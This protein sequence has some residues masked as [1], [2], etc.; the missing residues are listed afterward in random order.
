VTGAGEKLGAL[1][2]IFATGSN[3]VY[4]VRGERG[5]LL[6]PATDDVITSID[7]TSR[8]IT[9]EVVEGLEWVGATA[10]KRRPPR[11]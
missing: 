1:T 2:E 6:L 7:V 5:E 8:T 3:D 4:V 10:R 9:V 11:A